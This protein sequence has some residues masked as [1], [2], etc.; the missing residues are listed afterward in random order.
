MYVERKKIHLGYHS[1]LEEAIKARA[2]AEIK[3][4]F[5]AEYKQKRQRKLKA[6]A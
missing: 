4:N 1:T 3:Y 5:R 6:F 2:D